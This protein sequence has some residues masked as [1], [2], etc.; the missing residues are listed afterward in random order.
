M[1]GAE[2]M[3]VYVKHIWRTYDIMTLVVNHACQA[4]HIRKNVTTCSKTHYMPGWQRSSLQAW[5]M[6]IYMKKYLYISLNY[7]YLEWYILSGQNWKANMHIYNNCCSCT[8][9]KYQFGNAIKM[10]V[11]P[12][13]LVRWQASWPQVSGPRVERRNAGSAPLPCIHKLSSFPPR[14]SSGKHCYGGI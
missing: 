4:W 7:T 11:L 2:N 8:D 12:A 14:N 3:H 13:P 9:N 1:T 10:H 6:N 5:V